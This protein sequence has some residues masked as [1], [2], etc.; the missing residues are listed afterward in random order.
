MS[1]EKDSNL[2]RRKPPDL[3]SGAIDHSAISGQLGNYTKK[4]VEAKENGLSGQIYLI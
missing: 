2:R 1:G 4:P 3:Q